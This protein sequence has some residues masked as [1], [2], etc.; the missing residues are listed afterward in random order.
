MALLHANSELSETEIKK[1][2]PLTIATKNKM[3]RN[4][5]NQAGE[6]SQQW[7]L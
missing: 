6:K 1:A 7:K 5:F 3:P 4:K 2:I